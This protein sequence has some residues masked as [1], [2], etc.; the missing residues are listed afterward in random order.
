LKIRKAGPLDLD[1]VLEVE[2]RAFGNQH[3]QQI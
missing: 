3:I 2:T 1:A